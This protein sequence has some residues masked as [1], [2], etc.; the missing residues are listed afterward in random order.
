MLIH[1][2]ENYNVTGK[3]GNRIKIMGM[4]PGMNQEDFV[5]LNNDC[6]EGDEPFKIEYIEY[7]DQRSSTFKAVVAAE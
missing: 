1:F 3:A 2:L 5:V 4:F 6:E 7:M